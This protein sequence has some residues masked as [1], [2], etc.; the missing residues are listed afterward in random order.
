MENLKS[1]S[2]DLGAK[3]DIHIVSFGVP[4][5]ANYGGAIDVW[6][7]VRALHHQGLN[8]MLH[9]FVYGSFKP[10][11]AISEVVN[12]VHYYPRIAWPAIL[13]PGQ[14]YIVA[15]RKNPLLLARLRKDNAPILFEG[16]H[17]TGYVDQLKGRKLLLRAHNIEHQYYA[18]LARDSQRFA[19][20]F[21][22]RETLALERYE[23]NKAKAFDAIYAISK[24]DKAWFD[25]KGSNCVFLPVFHGFES[26]N[27]ASGRGKYLLYQGDLSVEM[28]QKSLLEVLKNIP[29]E[30]N[31]PMIVAGRSGDQ[32][33]EQK[34]MKYPNIQ[35]EIDVS[36]DRMSELIRGAQ[37]I[38]I[39]SRHPAGMKVKI[40]PALYQGR[41]I[42]ANENSLTHTYL[43]KALHI[44]PLVQ[45]LGSLLKK[46]WP[47][48]FSS[49]QYTERA[50]IL[51]HLPSDREKAKEI[52]KYL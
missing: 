21:F 48:E 36:S 11:D 52:I 49:A 8:I 34:L 13:S 17:T 47:L 7:R 38:I 26:L 28:N 39:H 40:F 29:Q 5:P 30:D 10:H 32:G 41:F 51:S 50:S 9:C 3:P 23:N 22:Q 37:V 6:N 42:A 18:G 19:Y 16:I 20:L 24:E 12:E 4:Y 2:G 46:L 43:D 33:F 15:S 35:R 25:S 1:P 31:Y 27:V 45:N 44:Y 14:P